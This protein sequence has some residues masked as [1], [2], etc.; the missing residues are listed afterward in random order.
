MRRFEGAGV[1]SC[2]FEETGTEKVELGA[3]VG[4]PLDELE[5]GDLSFDLAAAPGQ[6][7]RGTDGGGILFEAKGKGCELALLCLAQPR[8]ER[9]GGL[10]PDHGS[11][12]QG[13]VARL[14]DLRGG[15][16]ELLD[17][18]PL[19]RRQLLEAGGEHLRGATYRRN[20]NRSR[21]GVASPPCRRR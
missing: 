6:G 5:L 19:E 14:G 17:E 13:Q 20:R 9:V 15:G 12:P 2:G 11:K 16:E 7:Q 3:A 21:R 8:R 1:E 10:C 4:L 18:A